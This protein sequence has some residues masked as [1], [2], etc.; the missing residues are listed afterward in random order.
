MAV[1]K[2]KRTFISPRSPVSRGQ[3]FRKGVHQDFPDAL[4]PVLPKDAKVFKSG[5]VEPAEV[6]E[7]VV[8]VGRLNAE[9]EEK[10]NA[11]IEATLDG[12]RTEYE[13]AKAE[14][15]AERAEIQTL[16]EQAEAELKAAEE[17]HADAKPKAKKDGKDKS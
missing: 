7:D 11:Q 16:R 5:Y 15:D 13:E 10:M 6:S 3:R 9:A 1:V 2:L 12:Y 4:L 8:D 17:L 14:L